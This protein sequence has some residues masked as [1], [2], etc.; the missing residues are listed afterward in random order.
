MTTYRRTDPSHRRAYAEP[1]DPRRL[2]A[3][4]VSGGTLTVTGSGSNDRIDVTYGVET[5]DVR[6]VFLGEATDDVQEES[7]PSAD[8][9]RIVI[10]ALGGID[11]VHADKDSTLPASIPVTI[12]GG[13][14]DD[15]LFGTAGADVIDAGAD[16]DVVWAGGGND[17]VYGGGGEDTLN[18]EADNDTLSGGAGK[19]HLHGG[20]GDD[21]LTG[22]SGRDFMYGEAG[23]DRLYGGNGDD[24]LDGGGNVDKLYGEG[25]HDL[26]YGSSSN[27]RL[28][29][30]PGWDSLFGGTGTNYLDGG[31]DEDFGEN[32]PGTTL[33]SIENVI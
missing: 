10:E 9:Q 14:G 25:G 5:I 8:V 24:R 3:V 2:F 29:G 21:R 27:D 33:V 18:G 30:G 20:D 19:N 11:N 22:S 31:D 15:W 32:R 6:V 28:F 16:E 7:F 13:D 17:Y 1:L 23:R 26:L 12:R 4:S